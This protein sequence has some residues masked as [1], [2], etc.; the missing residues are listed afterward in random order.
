[1]TTNTEGLKPCP[2]CQNEGEIYR[3]YSA[4]N[5]RNGVLYASCLNQQCKCQMTLEHWNK[6]SRPTAQAS[7]AVPAAWLYT[8]HMDG[9][10]TSERSQVERCE[11][12]DSPWGSR[13]GVDYDASYHVTEEPLYRALSTMPVEPVTNPDDVFSPMNACQHRDTC[14]AALSDAIRPVVQD[15]PSAIKVQ[16]NIDAVDRLTRGDDPSES[17]SIV[18][19]LR[20]DAAWLLQ[21]NPD[22]EK[23]QNMVDA[24]NLI[25][26]LETAL[27]EVS[28][29]S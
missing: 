10:Q 12:G 22:D 19:C 6:L 4:G 13:P 27:M 17:E 29:E 7:E 18:A 23:A 26:Q 16:T 9:D 14:R 20:D 11:A 15:A 1:M 2:C 5:M 3:N 24:A 8:F 28:H 21:A 25:E